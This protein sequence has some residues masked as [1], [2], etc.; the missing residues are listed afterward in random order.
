MVVRT[1]LP[2]FIVTLASLFIIR[3][4]TV[5]ITRLVTGRTQVGGL[6]NVPGFDTAAT[7]F[8]SDIPLFGAAFP[9]SIVWWMIVAAFATWVLLRTQVRELDFRCRWQS[10]AARMVGVPVNRVKILLF[11]THRVCRVAGRH[12]R[13]HECAQRR[14]PA[15]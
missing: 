13:G 10:V 12:D 7:I 11:M 8:G 9:V 5:G 4:V 15:R 2:S 14:C 3:G 6:Q 1:Q